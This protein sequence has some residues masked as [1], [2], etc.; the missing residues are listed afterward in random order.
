MA[1]AG[2]EP[3]DGR[4]LVIVRWITNRKT[5][6]RIYPRSGKYFAFYVKD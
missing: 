4:R 1:K 2:E 5:G 3:P 6:Q